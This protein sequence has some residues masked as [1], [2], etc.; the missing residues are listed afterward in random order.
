MLKLLLAGAA[1]ALAATAFA[2]KEDHLDL[3][4]GALNVT[5]LPGR[6]VR[7]LAH[8]VPVLR[9][10]HLYIVK[11]GWSGMLMNQDQTPGTFETLPE[12][13][14]VKSGTAAFETDDAYARY[15]LEVRPD[16]T[17]TIVCTYGSKGKPAEVE[18]DMGY[19]NANI[20]Q[21]EPF[22]AKTI[23]GDR[24]GTVP[25][26][27]T[28]ADQ[29]KSKLT[30]DLTQIAFATKIGRI[31][32]SVTGDNP[33]NSALTL[34]DSRGAKHEWSLENPVFWLG[35]GVPTKPVKAGDNTVTITYKFGTPVPN[36]TTPIAAGQA[37]LVALKA[38][39]VPARPILPVIPHPKQMT[40]SKGGLRLPG[41]VR[42]VTVANPT[43]EEAQ[44]VRE[45]QQD[46]KELWGIE[47]E[48]VSGASLEN[49]GKLPVIYLGAGAAGPAG[50]PAL[51]AP[52]QA[53]GYSLS[54]SGKRAAILGTDARGAY[55][56]A[57]TLK[58]LLRVDA[59]GVFL[60]AAEIQDW[61]SLSMRGVHW[62][63]G[64]KSNAFH[65][66][67]ISRICAAMK[68]NT[69][70]FQVDYSEWSAQKAIWDK[71]RSTP[72][73][74]VKKT[75]DYSRQH[76]MEPIPLVNGLGHADWMFVNGQNL[77]VA[78]DPVR[79][80][81][82]DPSKA[83]V[84]T[85]ILF[86][87]M[88]EAID[89]FHPRI[90]H[91]GRDEI[92]T[93]GLFPPKGSTRSSTD[94]IL[95]DTVK[96]ND[97]LK[98]KGIQAMM[99]GDEFLHYPE[100]ASDA[101]NA[102]SVAEAQKRRAGL[103]KDII[104]ADWHYDGETTEFPSVAIWQKEGF[105]V[106]GCPWYDHGNIQNY[107]RVLNAEK[108]LGLIQTTWAG[109]TMSTDFVKGPSF[110]QF[111][112]YL[113]AAEYAWNGGT[114]GLDDLGY[115]PDEAFLQN[116][117]RKPVDMSKHKGFGV[118]FQTAASTNLDALPVEWPEKAGAKSETLSGTTFLA[119]KPM[120]LAGS[121]NPAGEWPKGVT[122]SLNGRTARELHFLWATTFRAAADTPVATVTVR[123]ADGASQTRPI[124]YARGIFAFE[125][126]RGGGEATT[127]W[128][129]KMKDGRPAGA[130]RWVFV[131]PTPSKAIE[132]VT[133]TSEGSEAAPVLL[134]LTGIE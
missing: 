4:A 82:Y 46:M 28:S 49:A 36:V 92:T 44:A 132:S 66:A 78:T 90:F 6:G 84:Y 45:L 38:A 70:L 41:K 116:W 11:P 57:Q 89:I 119:A 133:I 74:Q 53:E 24:A 14:G 103:P 131:N 25:L 68:M 22:T 127:V 80:Y 27:A 124:A 23:E 109:Y 115:D 94:L 67:M 83:R 98:A 95:E 33:G 130:R 32:I 26:F 3:S 72:L 56:G 59:K 43:P 126:L 81:Q 42:I 47:A 108:S 15:R 30:P 10:S 8:G 102:P 120:W 121:L 1:L 2:A 34:F 100:E 107:S 9:E 118:D 51:A 55:Y 71:S 101:G 52:K 20:L 16:N 35:I 12:K 97:W 21:G 79:R 62:F 85:D 17:L 7:V 86:P 37:K 61:P 31:G 54:V 13:D 104:I 87:V 113:L 60:Q 19:L 88:Q 123:Y 122:I 128:R 117:D 129:G 112:D 91:I 63:G 110:N 69:M 73:A 76:F 40:Q 29:I 50:A 125:D 93:G 77:D 105:Q 106:A 65:E 64:P 18:Y 5:M 75:V 114:P 58:Q 99:W 48:A 96:V 134:G 39:S 111:V